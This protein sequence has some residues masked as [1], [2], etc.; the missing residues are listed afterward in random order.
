M[1]TPDIEAG[2]L[3]L[4]APEALVPDPNQPR[5]DKNW[6]IAGLAA[7]MAELRSRGRGIR[8]TGVLFP[9][10]VRL[11]PGALDATGTLRRG[12]RLLIVDGEG[13][14][15]SAHRANEG[16]TGAVP[17][18]PCL[19]ED[20]GEEDAFEIAYMANSHRR[21]MSPLD[22]GLAL[23]RI[24][25]RHG[26]GYDRLAA[27]VNQSKD[28]VRDRLK[29]VA[30]EDTLPILEQRPDAI[31]LVRRIN[32][33]GRQKVP[34][35]SHPDGAQG[36][37]QSRHRRRNRR[38]TRGP[39]GRSLSRRKRRAQTRTRPRPRSQRRPLLALHF[40]PARVGSFCTN[41]AWVA[42]IVSFGRTNRRT[43]RHN[44]NAGRPSH[45]PP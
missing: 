7:N 26:L 8:G 5:Q 17:L 15:Q 32:Q 4:L 31:S 6:D 20:V 18:L 1:I 2:T 41:T 35:P 9:L 39:V 13:R 33:V 28:Y 24:K 10:L 45:K 12:V 36:R 29:A 43:K 22:E 11:P 44:D 25:K 16:H 14:W 3:V 23:L 34:R 38:Q 19:L 37:H 21:S 30:S 40:H 42:G 27:R